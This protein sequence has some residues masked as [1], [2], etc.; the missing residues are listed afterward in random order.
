[1][2]SN[3]ETAIAVISAIFVL[4][5]AMID[6]QASF[7]VAL[8]AIVIFVGYKLLPAKNQTGRETKKIV[9]AKKNRKVAKKIKK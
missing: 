4:F 6:P 8:V 7:V 5:T 1:M 2:N 9:V 3:T